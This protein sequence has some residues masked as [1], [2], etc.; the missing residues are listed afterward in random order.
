MIVPV[1][2]AWTQGTMLRAGTLRRGEEQDGRVS[3]TLHLRGSARDD[4][5]RGRLPRCGPCDNSFF[6]RR[7]ECVLRLPFAFF[8]LV[9]LLLLGL[10]LLAPF[11]ATFLRSFFRAA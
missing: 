8:L 10:S 11:L 5:G 7:R 4:F 2:Y 1:A 9:F 6:L 3:Q